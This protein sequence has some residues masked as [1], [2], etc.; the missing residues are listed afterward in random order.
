M[1]ASLVYGCQLGVWLPD[2]RMVVNL[3][4][5][6]IVYVVASLVCGC[7]FGMWL[8]IWY[9]KA[10]GLAKQGSEGEQTEN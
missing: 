6:F 2:W 1:V 5:S 9:E 10:D 7:Q 4:C 8:P 3:V